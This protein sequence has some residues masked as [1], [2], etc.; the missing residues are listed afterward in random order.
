[1][2]KVL[3]LCKSRHEIKGVTEYVFGN[4]LDP[5]AIEEMELHAIEKLRGVKQLDLYVTG[6]TVALVA[7]I[8]ACSILGVTLTLFHFNKETGEYYPQRV[9]LSTP[10]LNKGYYECC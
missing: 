9:K 10:C 5:L 4:T 6:L 3:G 1:M 2:K 7:V 8:N